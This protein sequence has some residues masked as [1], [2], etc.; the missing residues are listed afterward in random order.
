MPKT[1]KM[2]IHAKGVEISVLNGQFYVVKNHR[3]QEIGSNGSNG[4]G[5]WKVTSIRTGSFI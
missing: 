2:T 3:R 1:S 5:Y 4:K